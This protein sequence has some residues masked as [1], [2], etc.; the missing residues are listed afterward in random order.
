MEETFVRA[1]RLRLQC[2]EVIH[3]SRTRSSAEGPAEIPATIPLDN[4][5]V[6]WGN[7][8]GAGESD[9][10]FSVAESDVFVPDT[11]PSAPADKQGV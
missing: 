11:I 9:D 6:L 3:T 10:E 2:A 5:G 7:C 8:V 1:R 4:D